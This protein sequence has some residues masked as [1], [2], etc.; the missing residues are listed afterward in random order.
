[1]T[2]YLLRGVFAFSL[3]V[4]V[5]VCSA[6]LSG[7]GRAAQ[8]PPSRYP[9]D[10]DVAIGKAYGSKLAGIQRS[11]TVWLNS[12]RDE[13]AL[14]AVTVRG[15]RRDVAGFQFINTAGWFTMWR[16]HAPTAAVPTTQRSIVAHL[17]RRVAADCRS[18]WAP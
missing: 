13:Y 2:R 9:L 15:G 5:A 17:V 18:P 4:L 12:G 6:A 11:C 1:M 3:F 14:A 16:F 10:L 8:P 7:V